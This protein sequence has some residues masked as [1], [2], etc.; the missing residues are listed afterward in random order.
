MEHLTPG[1]I[2]VPPYF[3]V[4]WQKP[5]DAQLYWTRDKMRFPDPLPP[6]AY[7][8]ISIDAMSYA[9][10]HYSVP[11]RL[12]SRLINYYYYQAFVPGLLP[13]EEMEAAAKRV[14]EN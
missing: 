12:Y 1:P 4:A 13:A 14:K 8:A 10:E 3:P 11:L 7:A 6:L 9:L 5:A 2:A